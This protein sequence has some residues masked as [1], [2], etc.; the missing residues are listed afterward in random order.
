MNGSTSDFSRRGSSPNISPAPSYRATTTR[1]PYPLRAFSPISRRSSSVY[2]YSSLDRL[3]PADGNDL[4]PTRAGQ[5]RSL[6]PRQPL[7]TQ[8]PTY[9]YKATLD[10]PDISLVYM[11][12][13]PPAIVRET[14]ITRYGTLS[15][16]H[17]QLNGSNKSFH[18]VIPSLHSENGRTPGTYIQPPASLTPGGG[19]FR[20]VRF[21]LPSNIPPVPPH[22]SSRNMAPMA[23]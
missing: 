9:N 23:S 14:G 12:S 16:G 15:S 8:R 10:V 17:A 19:S 6:S 7:A 2:S 11:P 20:A 21:D 3:R 1:D 4:Q 5:P 22:A 13:Q 18:S